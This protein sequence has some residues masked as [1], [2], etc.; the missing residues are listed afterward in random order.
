MFRIF[1]LS[2]WAA[3]QSQ[4]S[5]RKHRARFKAWSQ[6]SWRKHWARFK[7]WWKHPSNWEREQNHWDWY[8]VNFFFFIVFYS[9]LVES[10]FFSS[11]FFP[12]L[13]FFSVEVK[14]KRSTIMRILYRENYAKTKNTRDICFFFF[15]CISFVN[16]F[17]CNVILIISETLFF[18]FFNYSPFLSLPFIVSITQSKLTLSF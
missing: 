6:C 15:G 9:C 7:A 14:G 3:L 8:L 13:C 18:F 5:W 11:L 1:G 4:C 10:I 12:H 17:L 2:L 16:H